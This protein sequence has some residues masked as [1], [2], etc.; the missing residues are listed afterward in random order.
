MVATA[1]EAVKPDAEERALARA[2]EEHTHVYR[3]VSG[4]WGA[5]STSR[6]GVI[7]WLK[8]GRCP[9]EAGQRGLTCKHVAAI[10]SAKVATGKYARCQVCGRIGRTGSEVTTTLNYVGGKGLEPRTYCSDDAA[11]CWR[12]WDAQHGL[13]S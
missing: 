12:R 4:Q 10:N 8:D 1:R 7:Y 6:R 11:A 13:V 2:R 9:C 5:S 3:H